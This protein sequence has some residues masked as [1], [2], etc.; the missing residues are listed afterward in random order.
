MTNYTKTR[1][2]ALELAHYAPTHWQYVDVTDRQ[3]KR[4]VGPIYATKLEALADLE[5]YAK[6]GGWQ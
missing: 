6:R 2:P 1:V 4:Q 5:A 3:R